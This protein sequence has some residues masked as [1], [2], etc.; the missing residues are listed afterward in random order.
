MII[1]KTPVRISFLG[2]GTDYPEH[3]EKHGGS[4]LVTTID[5]YSYLSVKPAVSH[6]FDYGIRV[7]YSKT[8]LVSD[9][10]KIAHPSV[11]ECLKFLKIY[12]GIEIYYVGDL[13]ARTGLGSSSS[14][15][16]GLL[17]A[18]HAFKGEMVSSRQLAEEAV[19]VEREMIR[20]RI[21]LQDQYASAFGGLLFLKFHGKNKVDVHPVAVS[22]KRLKMINQ[23]LMLFYTGI[24]RNAHEI[25]KEQIKKTEVN[26][27]KLES[28]K[29]LVEEGV[30]IISNS[31]KN[32][33]NFGEL[34]NEGWQIKRQLSSKI[35]NEEIDKT[36]SLAKKAG[37]VGGKLLGAGGGGFLLLYVEPGKKQGVRKALRHLKEVEF[38]FENEGSR[39]I[40]YKV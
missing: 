27:T 25:L 8:E 6:F 13:P 37:A 38:L 34:L 33:S 31:K 22:S 21:G 1:T 20:E 12:K 11:R 18:L 19:L 32:L 9:V 16:V 5:K 35:T 3:F 4:V 30:A 10:E 26:K 14:F 15:T 29:K 39:L 17:H 23:R 7:S 2:G 28:L 24:R 36:Y 40:F